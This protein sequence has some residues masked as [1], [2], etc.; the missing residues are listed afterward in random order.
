MAIMKLVGAAQHLR[1]GTVELRLVLLLALGSV[2]GSLLG[3]L[4]LPLWERLGISVDDLLR[5][6][7]GVVLVVAA[8][9]L[10]LR[11]RRP[12]SMGEGA[13][14]WAKAS[15]VLASFVVGMLVAWTSVGSG[16]LLMALMASTVSLPVVKLVGTDLV[17]AC[18][19]T[20]VAGAAHWGIGNVDWG[21]V[22]QLLLGSIP[23]VLAGSYLGRRF[24]DERLRAVVGM[25]MLAVGVRLL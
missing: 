9:F 15:L 17:N 3:T 14:P 18:L 6:L 5:H 13:Y 12:L 1:Q 16:V 22:L 4:I 7:L 10:L 8:G 25:V 21:L 24:S 20:L 11:V 2:P 23:G 19:I